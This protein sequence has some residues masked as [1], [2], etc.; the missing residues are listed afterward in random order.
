MLFWKLSPAHGKA[1]DLLCNRP[2]PSYPLSCDWDL[3]ESFFFVMV[4]PTSHLRVH[5]CEVG[6]QVKTLLKPPAMIRLTVEL[7][8]RSTESTAIR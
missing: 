8:I 2:K 3:I 1:P 7:R 4:Q 6:D 5:S